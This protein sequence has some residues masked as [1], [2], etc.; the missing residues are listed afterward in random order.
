MLVSRISKIVVI[1]LVAAIAILFISFKQFEHRHRLSFVPDAFN[2][3]RIIY[4]RE[5]SWGFGPGGNES[6]VMVYE[7]PDQVAIAI[8]NN[9]LRYFETMPPNQRNDNQNGRYEKWQKTPLTEPSWF[10]PGGI[11]SPRN[12]QTNTSQSHG[13]NPKLENYLYRYGFG[14]SLDPTLE[15]EINQIVSKPGAFFAQ[16]RTGIIIVSPATKK[17]IYAYSG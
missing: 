2:V 6:G 9:G 10:E 4:A 16:G 15:N 8:Q 14:I 5:E 11:R 3:S 1:T 13:S 17:V 12:D 7:L